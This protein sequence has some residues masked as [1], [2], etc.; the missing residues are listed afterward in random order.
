M[1]S[2]AVIPKRERNKGK[3]PAMHPGQPL[4]RAAAKM[5]KNPATE[6]PEPRERI[7]FIQKTRREMLVP[8]RSA[9]IKFKKIA[10]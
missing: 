1:L 5:P 9:I 3:R 8:T 6:P 4:A 7:S 2:E 10:G